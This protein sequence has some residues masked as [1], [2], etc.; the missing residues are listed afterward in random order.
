MS[1]VLSRFHENACKTRVPRGCHRLYRFTEPTVEDLS[2]K[3][4]LRTWD[5]HRRQRR[6][7]RACPIG[8]TAISETC[9]ARSTANSTCSLRGAVCG[10]RYSQESCELIDIPDASVTASA[11][12]PPTIAS[13]ALPPD[14]QNLRNLTNRTFSDYFVRRGSF[15]QGGQIELWSVQDD[16]PA[17]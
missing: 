3:K 15:S 2:E 10:L 11:A 8:S 9:M 17:P 5:R 7:R 14:C 4:T 13:N 16:P 12:W 1:L 6:K